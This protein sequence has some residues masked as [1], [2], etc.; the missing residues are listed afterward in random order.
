MT[1]AFQT[2]APPAKKIKKKENGIQLNKKSNKKKRMKPL[3]SHMRP[4][5]SEK[6]KSEGVSV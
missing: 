4:S 1:S 2:K 5:S 3:K 6:E